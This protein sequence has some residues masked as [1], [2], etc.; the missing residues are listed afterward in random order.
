M[1][2]GRR[3][4]AG[5]ALHLRWCNFP[6]H[7]SKVCLTQPIRTLRVLFTMI[8]VIMRVK[9]EWFSL[10]YNIH[11]SRL[12]IYFIFSASVAFVT[13]AFFRSPNYMNN[14]T[15]LPCIH[16]YIQAG[17]WPDPPISA[18]M[19]LTRCYL[20]CKRAPLMELIHS[21]VMNASFFFISTQYSG[22]EQTYCAQGHLE[23]RSV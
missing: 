4:L 2:M 5:L 19:S 6:V 7:W 11:F 3:P 8:F 12:W 23:R 10:F 15:L 13:V 17:I 22:T 18:Y 14:K 1:C 20:R 21:F 9:R 16:G